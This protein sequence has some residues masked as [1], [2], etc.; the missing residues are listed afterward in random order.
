MAKGIGPLLLTFL[1]LLAV[2]VPAG[3]A[4]GDVMSI[5][6]AG[7]KCFEVSVP[8][9]VRAGE[10]IEVDLP[11]E[12]HD[13]EELSCR[14]SVPD[15]V[16]EGESFSVESEWG[17][18]DVCCP[19]GCGAGDEILVNVPQELVRDGRESASSMAPTG[20]DCAEDIS[21]HRFRPGQRVEVLRTNGKYALA[22]IVLGY[23]CLFDIYY[24]VRLDD[25][26]LKPAVPEEEIFEVVDAPPEC[27]GGSHSNPMGCAPIERH[28]AC[29]ARAVTRRGRAAA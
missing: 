11:A 16:R 1:M 9:G 28:V 3:L 7:G 5:E 19:D 13:D 14:L 12:D 20:G 2:E 8:E 10:S 23:D 21:H 18:F 25:A 17:T 27:A 22:T 4:S 6:V 15:G 29:P 26:Q 24:E